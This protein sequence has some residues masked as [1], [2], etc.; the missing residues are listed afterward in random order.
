MRS[1]IDHVE[2]TSLNLISNDKKFMTN[3]TSTDK[4]CSI[5]FINFH[6]IYIIKKKKKWIERKSNIKIFLFHYN[7]AMFVFFLIL[8]IFVPKKKKKNHRKK[9]ANF[10]APN[11]YLKLKNS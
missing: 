8:F 5:N 6:Q 4:N 9:T 11:R 10:S 1:K 2:K 7:G 3:L